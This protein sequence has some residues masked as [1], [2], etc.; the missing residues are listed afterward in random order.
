[1]LWWRPNFYGRK[2]KNNFLIFF[3]MKTSIRKLLIPSKKYFKYPSICCN[4]A[5][6]KG[7]GHIANNNAAYFK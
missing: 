5:E 3:N 2:W 6:N 1:M 7:T 4:T